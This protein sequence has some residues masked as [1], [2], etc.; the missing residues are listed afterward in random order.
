MEC[1]K[2]VAHAYPLGGVVYIH[3]E[4][5]HVVSMLGLSVALILQVSGLHLMM[6]LKV[7]NFR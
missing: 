3:W 1:P 4:V 5:W 6:D 2:N 7:G